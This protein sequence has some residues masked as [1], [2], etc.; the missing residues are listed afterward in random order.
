MKNG[1]LIAQDTH[2]KL[3]QSCGEYKKLWDCSEASASWKIKN[4]VRV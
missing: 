4:G 3:L 1:E 2:E